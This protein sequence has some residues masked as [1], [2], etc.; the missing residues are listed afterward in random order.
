MTISDIK[1][2]LIAAV[3]GQPLPPGGAAALHLTTYKWSDVVNRH[4][5][6]LIG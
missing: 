3:Y 1:T 5:Y 6:K 2:S 4:K